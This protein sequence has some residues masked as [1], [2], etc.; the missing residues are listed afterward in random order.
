LQ[1]FPCCGAVS[2]SGPQFHSYARF[3]CLRAD[4]PLG[5]KSR[6]T[7]FSRC[8]FFSRCPISEDTLPPAIVPLDRVGRFFLPPSDFIGPLPQDLPITHLL[9]SQG[10]RL[11]LLN[12][13]FFQRQ[14]PV[15]VHSPSA[16]SRPVF[17]FSLGLSSP[18]FFFFLFRVF[19]RLFAQRAHA[20]GRQIR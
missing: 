13:F 1:L 6:F 8:P 3:L 10:P 2:T 4:F 18:V 7:A 14:S 11:P 9:Y 12:C 15:L 17:P 20:R 5:R 16:S 19:A